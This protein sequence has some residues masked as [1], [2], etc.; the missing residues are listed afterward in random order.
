M[1]T[2]VV[3]FSDWTVIGTTSVLVYVPSIIQLIGYCLSR[4]NPYSPP[5]PKL[6]LIDD[7]GNVIQKTLQSDSLPF[8]HALVVPQLRIS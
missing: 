6:L 2:S 7:C 4:R 1:D 8:T 3:E 5:F